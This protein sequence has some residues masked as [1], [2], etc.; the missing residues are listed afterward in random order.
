MFVLQKLMSEL[1]QKE[2]H[3]N[4]LRG[5]VDNLLKNK[6]PASDKIQVN[7]CVFD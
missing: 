1:E 5:K 4:V 6:H 2:I 3:L 7:L